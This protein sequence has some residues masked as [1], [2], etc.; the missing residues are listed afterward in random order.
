MYTNEVTKLN[1]VS[2]FWSEAVWSYNDSIQWSNS[3]YKYCC[4]IYM[5]LNK[6]LFQIAIVIKTFMSLDSQ[7]AWK[8]TCKDDKL[9]CLEEI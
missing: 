6:K 3:W 9:N 1:V 4:W 5:L 8:N 2:V 7:F